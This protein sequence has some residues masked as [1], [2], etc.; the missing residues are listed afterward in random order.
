MTL[1]PAAVT[2]TAVALALELGAHPRF[3]AFYDRVSADFDGWFGIVRWII[4]IAP[5]VEKG[6][7]DVS[8]IKDSVS[9]VAT[10]ERVVGHIANRVLAPGGAPPSDDALTTFTVWAA[11]QG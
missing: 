10:I 9:V 8:A 5:H 11:H 7:A 3:Q 1:D 2:E 4:R 6:I